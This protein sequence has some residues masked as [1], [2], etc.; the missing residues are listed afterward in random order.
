M[1]GPS[2]V[3][4]GMVL[5]FALALARPRAASAQTDPRHAVD[6]LEPAE[7]GS[8]WFASESL[9]LRGHLRPSAGYVLSFAHRS[10][11]V[12]SSDRAPVKN[13][14]LLHVG[15]SLV[16]FDRLRL[17]L[18]LPF[19]VYADGDDALEGGALV[20]APEKE[21]GIGDLRLGADLR[22]LGQHRQAITVAVGV[23]AWAPTG[24]KSQW[25]SDGVFRA[26]PRVLA[27]GEAGAFVWAAQLGVL[28][29]PSAELGGSLGAGVRIAKALVVGPELVVSTVVDDALGKRATPAEA[30]LG[31]HWLVDGTARIGLGLGGGLTEG[32][33]APAWRA[34][35]GVEWAPEIPKVKR[36]R[37]RPIVDPEHTGEPDEDHD[38]IPDAHDACP[39]VVGIRSSDPKTHGCPPDADGDGVDDLA[40]ACP[41]VPGLRTTDPMTNGCP[42]RDRDGD[43][44]P[45]DLD[46]CPDDRG[47]ADIEPRRNGCPAAFVRGSRIELL[48]PIAW[49]GAGTEL[50]ATPDNE[51]ILT[52]VLGVLL[53]LPT[54]R[55]LRIEGHADRT[56]D[57]RTSAARAAA[58]AKWLVDH[59][60]DGARITTE[61][62]GGDRP[63]ATNETES[64]RAANRR[65][66]LHLVP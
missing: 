49:K 43:G 8:E 41:T 17:A 63:I 16:L 15:G 47:A 36:P 55:A 32:V 64:G 13:E 37:P 10:R 18:D 38:G 9:D 33:G 62:L 31:A 61:G 54:T 59:G 7:R 44:I 35:F 56:G 40:D 42:D 12:P 22:V 30:I 28:L 57:R 39:K 65:V 23:Q 25:T 45:N 50:A 53:K 19:Q 27:S 5:A 6:R 29:R 21:G 4:I 26:R 34:I 48:D 46:A 20:P 2:G 14:A 1:K 11:V 51:A 58:V 60:I 24:Q 66:E 52:A 3:G